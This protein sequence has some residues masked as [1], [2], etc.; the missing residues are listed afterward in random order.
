MIVKKKNKILTIFKRLFLVMLSTVLIW[1]GF[2]H[3]MK[4]LEQHKYPAIGQYVQIENQR[5]HIYT[6]GNGPNTIVLLS[7]LGTVSPVLDFEPL[8][9]EMSNHNRVVVLE[10]FGYGWSDKT[11]KKRTVEHI[12]GELRSALQQ[13]NIKGPYVLMPHSISG[14]YS[15][16]Y[17]HEYPEEVKAVVGIDATLPAALAYF[18]ESPP[19]IPGYMRYAAPIGLARL[20]VYL[21]GS[22]YLPLASEGAYSD[23][24]LAMTKAMTAWN[25]YNKNVIQEASELGDNVRKTAQ[26]SFP[27]DIPVLFFTRDDGRVSEDGRSQFTFLQTQL[28]DHPASTILPLQGHHYLHWTKSKEMS[29]AV[30]KFL[31]DIKDKQ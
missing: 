15:M 24:N 23:E 11:D 25:G 10:P 18:N 22:A 17:A 29:E 6:K 21:D 2:H 13:L 30:L 14:I 31:K 4:L 3:V 9:N 19:A 1:I 28:T 26:M 7:G 5:M 20:A 12:V 16:Y 27:P 8:I